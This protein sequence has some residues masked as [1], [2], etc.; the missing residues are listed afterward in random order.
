MDKERDLTPDEIKQ[1]LEDTCTIFEQVLKRLNRI[2]AKADNALE[3]LDLTFDRFSELRSDVDALKRRL[4]YG[5]YQ[6][7]PRS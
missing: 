6:D 1:C 4:T 7:S 5:K 3:Q 2:E